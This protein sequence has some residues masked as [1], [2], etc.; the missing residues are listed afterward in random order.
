MDSKDNESKDEK[1][2]G[3]GDDD[4]DDDNDND[5]NQEPK[6]GS[7]ANVICRPYSLDKSLEELKFRSSRF[8]QVF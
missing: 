8:C 4:D 7:E 6:Q 5:K 3:G 2:G 1:G